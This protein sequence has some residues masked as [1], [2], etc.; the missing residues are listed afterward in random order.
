MIFGLT[1]VFSDPARRRGPH[2]K[3]IKAQ[4]RRRRQRSKA[5]TPS[6]KRNR[7]LVSMPADSSFMWR[8]KR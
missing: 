1:W 8:R 7:D 5:P 6:R 3:S 4:W 2:P